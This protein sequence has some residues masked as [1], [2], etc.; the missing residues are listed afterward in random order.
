MKHVLPFPHYQFTTYQLYFLFQYRS[1][2]GNVKIDEAKLEE[3][4]MEKFSN[5]LAH[6]CKMPH[7]QRLSCEAGLIFNPKLSHV[8]HRHLKTALKDFIWLQQFRDVMSRWFSVVNAATGKITGSLDSEKLGVLTSMT[9]VDKIFPPSTYYLCNLYE[10]KFESK[11]V[12]TIL[13]K[14]M[15]YK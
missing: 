10:M 12:I 14:A 1:A 8:M 7:V 4:G 15:V 2:T 3:Y 9:T 5:F 11:T 6:V 13:D